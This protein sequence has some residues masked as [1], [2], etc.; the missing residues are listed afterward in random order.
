M[1]LTAAELIESLSVINDADNDDVKALYL[2]AAE[3]LDLA[4]V[5][6]LTIR[7]LLDI[8]GYRDGALYAL[9]LCMFDLLDRGGICLSLQSPLLENKLSRFTQ[10]ADELASQI[11]K[12]IRNWPELIQVIS[13][14][15]AARDDQEL[16]PLVLLAEKGTL[17]FQKYYYSEQRVN[18]E[19]TR[20]IKGPDVKKPENQILISELYHV[21]VKNPL[22]FRGE[23]SVLNPGQTM[24]VL[25]P[26]LRKFVIVSGGPGTGKTSIVVNILRLFAR[27]GI[28]PSRMMVAAPTGRAAQRLTESI[29]KGL[30]SLEIKEQ[31]DSALAGIEAMTV[32]RL[33]KFSPSSNDFFYNRSNRLKAD[34]VIVDEVSMVDV[35]LLA[36]LLS[37]VDDSAAL[38]MLGDKNQLPSVEA[39]AVLADL[40][41]E[42]SM[43]TYSPEILSVLDEVHQEAAVRFREKIKLAENPFTD[44]FVIL[45]QG[46]R[47]DKSIVEAASRIIKQ[48][49]PVVDDIPVIR[50]NAAIPEWGIYRVDPGANEADRRKSLQALLEQWAAVNFNPGDGTKSY[51]DLVTQAGRY[52][53]ENFSDDEF[54]RLVREIYG[55]IENCRILSPV[56]KGDSGT[57]QINRQMNRIMAAALTNAGGPGGVCSGQP[58]IITRNDYPQQL[59]NGDTGVVLRASDANLYAFFPSGGRFRFFPLIMTPAS[60]PAWAITVHKSQGS[61]YDRV[62]LVLDEKS[63]R[64]LTGEIVYTAVTRARSC[65]VIHST[66]DTLLKAISTRMERESGIS[67]AP[68]AY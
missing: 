62:L 26:L 1:D 23:P 41:P 36:D 67:L 25:L 4:A 32:H 14:G 6:F 60:E 46:Y 53:T 58:V 30:G 10:N 63:E 22:C 12:K 24:A 43:V 51:Q 42:E 19:L 56:R 9:L 39:G 37:A 29:R 27:M 8:S 45:D 3:N 11:R 52:S 48:E 57:E 34:L 68:L 55:H 17:Y 21:L 61:E 40:M 49:S 2:A 7:D 66:K 16:R 33:L 59:Y 38:V 35:I 20:L 64:L 28:D 13:A 54:V 15:E 47:S 50:K 44:H 31:S 5:D 18:S 65:A